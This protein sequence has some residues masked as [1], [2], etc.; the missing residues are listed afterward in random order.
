[1]KEIIAA[2]SLAASAVLSKDN[3]GTIWKSWFIGD[4]KKQRSRM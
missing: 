4:R 2:K 3:D 1:M